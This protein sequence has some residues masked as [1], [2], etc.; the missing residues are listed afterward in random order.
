MLL[1]FVKKFS[2][3]ELSKM[4]DGFSAYFTVLILKGQ[5]CCSNK[6]LCTQKMY[7][8]NANT[9][10]GL[11]NFVPAISILTKYWKASWSQ[12]EEN[13]VVAECKSSKNNLRL[14]LSN[15]TVHQYMKRLGIISK[16]ALRVPH[17]L[18]ERNLL[19]CIN[20]CNALIR[21]QRNDPLLSKCAFHATGRMHIFC[22]KNYELCVDLIKLC[23]SAKSSEILWN[24]IL[25][26]SSRAWKAVV[27]LLAT[28]FKHAA[29]IRVGLNKWQN[30]PNYFLWRFKSNYVLFIEN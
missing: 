10:I 20:D 23:H 17:V 25:R 26:N 29:K 8:P 27:M 5:K 7:W 6:A 2:F 19:H 12:C 13:K 4:E 18:T 22:F 30:K 9:K 14:N 21:H 24:L 15:G 16:L 11:Q 1:V 28:V 3:G